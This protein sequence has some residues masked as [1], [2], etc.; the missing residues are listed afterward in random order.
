MSTDDQNRKTDQETLVAYLDGELSETEI[1][2]VEKR[3]TINN[4]LRQQ[5]NG[6]ERTWDMLDELCLLYTS[7]SP[8]D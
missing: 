6:L 3:L 7:P 2:E 5:L 1:V 4:D 8:R